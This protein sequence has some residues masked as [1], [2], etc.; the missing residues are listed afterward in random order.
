MA[1]DASAT[2]RR[3]AS[4]VKSPARI[5]ESRRCPEGRPE[6]GPRRV[7]RDRPAATYAAADLHS[8][9]T[10]PS[11]ALNVT[12]TNPASDSAT[13]P[14]K[15]AA[16][17]CIARVSNSPDV[18]CASASSGDDVEVALKPPRKPLHAG[19]TDAHSCATTPPSASSS[20]SAAD[21]AY[22]NAATSLCADDSGR[23]ND[24]VVVA[25]KSASTARAATRATSLSA[26]AFVS[27]G[28]KGADATH[29]SVSSGVA[30]SCDATNGAFGSLRRALSC[31]RV[32]CS[33]TVRAM[34]SKIS[35]ASEVPPGCRS[36]L[37]RAH[38]PSRTAARDHRSDASDGDDAAV[39]LATA[40]ASRRTR[41]DS[42]GHGSGIPNRLAARKRSGA[43]ATAGSRVNEAVA[44]SHAFFA[45]D[46]DVPTGFTATSSKG[47][48]SE[49][50]S[51]VRII[52][53]PRCK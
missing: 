39:A 20:S 46:A 38:V 30:P 43:R 8:S 49:S 37:H 36:L 13:H 48:P 5:H 11:G 52:V 14:G 45:D 42:T 7:A 19:N 27:L 47:S 21:T 22:V 15:F 2:A 23:S 28:H 33:R 50:S 32:A 29:A 18:C 44:S 10:S 9:P 17:A 51:G 40:S 3:I 6:G 25:P 1:Q 53:E 16:V 26:S 41:G 35:L 34:E 4:S 31:A 24:V 12:R